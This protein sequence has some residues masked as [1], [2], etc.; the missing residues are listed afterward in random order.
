MASSIE[1]RLSA[2]YVMTWWLSEITIITLETVAN[3]TIM[4][5]MFVILSLTFFCALKIAIVCFQKISRPPPRR[6]LEILEG[7]GAYR[8]RKFLWGGGFED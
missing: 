8:P 7:S 2:V 3:S 4:A 6:E 5:K 1:K